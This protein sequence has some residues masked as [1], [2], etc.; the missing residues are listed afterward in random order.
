MVLKTDIGWNTRAM[1]MP[2]PEEGI[3]PS[4]ASVLVTEFGECSEC[5]SGIDPDVKDALHEDRD[6][7]W[8]NDRSYKSDAH[9]CSDCETE[10]R[11]FVEEKAFGVIGESQLPDDA[12]DYDDVYFIP[13]EDVNN[14]LVVNT[15]HIKVSEASSREPRSK[16][17]AGF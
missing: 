14:Y 1:A 9:A 16:R 8:R 12:D 11:I 7:I 6:V 3:A 15:F 13:V 5:C 10:L 17:R 2:S 4:T